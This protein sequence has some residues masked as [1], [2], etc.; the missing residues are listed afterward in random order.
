[1]KRAALA[2]LLAAAALYV[3]ASALQSQTPAWGYVAA[4]AG[5]A[6][7]GAMADWF[8]VVALFRHPMGLPIPHTA[9]VPASKDRIGRQLA[10][11]IATHFLAT[12]WVLA[13][14]RGVDEQLRRLSR[15]RTRPLLQRP[16]REAVLTAMAAERAPFY[17]E[18]ADLRLCTDGCTPE[19]ACKMLLPRIREAWRGETA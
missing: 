2:L 14:L 9:I 16:D 6:L 10:Q 17:A 3:L 13:R 18:V 15:D 1:M 11:F 5:A 8:A 7:V 19:Q 12:D 4:F